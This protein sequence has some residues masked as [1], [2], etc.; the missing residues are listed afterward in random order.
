[1]DA[2]KATKLAQEALI[3][4]HSH[5][6]FGQVKSVAHAILTAC[7]AEAAD[8]EAL[9]VRLE[10]S[11]KLYEMTLANEMNWMEK[12]EEVT[13][14][15]DEARVACAE[16]QSTLRTSLKIPKA[17]MRGH[18]TFEQWDAACQK[19]FDAIDKPICT[20]ALEAR[21]REARLE[22][23]E[24]WFKN[25]KYS[26]HCGCEEIFGLCV[27]HERLAALKGAK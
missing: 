2:D 13:K 16:M 11:K 5:F 25:T 7:T 19:V 20:N 1:M 12:W 23:A 21:L 24:W 8:C 3:D 6:N 15:R 9:K 26:K 27:W 4:A 18:I 22:E 10:H 17:W 14:E